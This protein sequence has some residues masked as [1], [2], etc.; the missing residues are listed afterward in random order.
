MDF[1]IPSPSKTTYTIYTRSK[2]SFCE[3]AK[4]LLKEYKPVIVDCD[5]YLENDLN[6]FLAYMEKII[7]RPYKMFP[8]IFHNGKFIGGFFETKQYMDKLQAFSGP[9]DSSG[10]SGLSRF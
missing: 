3:K 8:M 10:S 9:S 1:L 6:E 4:M 7:G 5:R 2:C